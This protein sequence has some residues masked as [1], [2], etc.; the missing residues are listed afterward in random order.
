MESDGTEPIRINQNQ[1]IC[2]IEPTV[3]PTALALLC[4]YGRVGTVTVYLPRVSLL[5]L[6]TFEYFYAQIILNLG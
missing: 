2:L 3:H 6:I 5:L 4:Q 1:A